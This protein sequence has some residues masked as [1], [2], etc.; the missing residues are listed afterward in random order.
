MTLDIPQQIA[1]ALDRVLPYVQKPARYTG[2]EFNSVV[3]P[4][5]DTRYRLALVFPDIY[6]LGM[7]NL[8]LAILYDTVNRRPDMLAE[9][10]FI[11][12]VDMIAAMRR[13]EIPL[14]SL[15]SRR[16][17]REFDVVGFSLPYEQ[18][19]T[20]VLTALDLA[21]IPLR[22]RDRD[23]DAPLI[24]AGGSAAL[25]PEPMHA[26]FDAFFIGEG[27]DAI[28]EILTAWTDARR[29]GLPRVERLKRLAMIEGI[30]V[31]AFYAP[32][33]G[34]DGA[35]VATRPLAE[36]ASVAPAVVTKR[37]VPVL[38]PPPTRFI[39]PFIDIVHNR[40]AIEIQRGCTRGCRFCQAGM[41]YRPVRERPV[42]EIAAA[43]DEIVRQTG[44]EE[45]GLLSLSSSD[46]SAVGELV[47]ELMARHGDK[48]L[49][50][51]LPSLRIETFS[52]DLMERLEKGRRRSG[53]TFAPEAA[54]DRLRN[55]I[56]KPIATEAL[57]D[58]AREVYRRGWTTIKLYFMIGHPTQTLE[59]VEAIAD[60]AHEVRKI[61]FSVLGKKSNVRVGVSTLA[62]KPHT[63][64]QWLPVAD[65]G[66]LREQIRLLERRLRGPG[67]EFSWNDPRETLLEAALSRGDRRLADVIRRAWEL[68]AGFDGWGDQFNEAAWREAFAQHSLDPDWYARRE[69]PTDEALPWDHIDAGVTKRFMAREYAN[70]LAEIPLDDCRRY[71]EDSDREQ[72][73]CYACGILTQFREERRETDPDAWGCPPLRSERAPVALFAEAGEMTPA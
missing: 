12:W 30:Y 42:A 3:K 69:R 62:P 19:Y 45:I 6:D 56:N 11:P 70:A 22:A 32:E 5:A 65:E 40:A 49:S 60:L 48:K 28:T 35:L 14:Y 7:S 59:D 34:E 51:G 21:G 58:V 43:V 39:V 26:F 20:N 53:F 15:E 72:G 38:P 57:L 44:F 27:E 67:I 73:K 54:T 50:V 4:W 29:Q 2:G 46:Y 68:G 63:P 17:L 71:P 10:A 9:R 24:L 37:I 64:F 18:L 33:Y 55:V 61:G 8:G 23:D 47:S 16:P 31:P 1:Q 41:V 52:V 36:F 66:T 25:N 13:A